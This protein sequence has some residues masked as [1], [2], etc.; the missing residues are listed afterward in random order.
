MTPLRQ[1][2]I[3]D[4]RIRN[5]AVSTIDSYTYHLACFA[6]FHGRSPEQL[7]PEEIRAYQV[8][9]VTVKKVSWSTFNQTVC[10]LRFFYRI[11]LPRPWHVEMI[12][13][14]KQPKTLPVVLGGDEV[15]RFLACVPNSFYRTVLTTLY[16]A[17]LRLQEGLHLRLTDIDSARMLLQVRH[18]KGAKERIVPLSPR[19]LQELREHWLRTTPRPTT[20]LFPGRHGQPYSETNIQK[21][22]H[23]AAAAAKLNKRVTPHT[24]RHSY[25]TGLLEAGV[26][27]LT[28][29]KLLG[30]RS[31]STT[32][33]YLH[34]RQPYMNTVASPL[35]LLPI[36][37]C[38]R[39][40]PPEQS[41]SEPNSSTP[42]PSSDQP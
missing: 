5:Y 24:L 34:V 14:G 37:Q 35:D 40:V 33:I 8:H 3:D 17:G 12:P 10:A 36:A 28:I 13:F 2:F 41:P 1:R 39:I 6:K 18:G 22:C 26:D 16:A 42:P 21:V 15:Q 32:L 31:F 30:H 27:L 29:Q 38:P 11:T 4:L 25:A 9:L 7:G 19:L 23:R 20:W